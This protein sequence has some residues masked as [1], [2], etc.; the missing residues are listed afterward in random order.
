MNIKLLDTLCC[1]KCK[2]ALNLQEELYNESEIIKGNLVCEKCSETYYILQGIPS[3]YIS[4]DEIIA[5]SKKLEFD[6]F[7]ITSDR[8]SAL[9]KCN[10]PKNRLG[11]LSN[12]QI[13]LF[14]VF[15]GWLL[16]FLTCLWVAYETVT[17][18]LS[19]DAKPLSLVF[20][21]ILILIL[22]TSDYIIYRLDAKDRYENQLQRLRQLNDGRKLSEYDS[23]LEFKDNKATYSD[24]SKPSPKAKEIALTLKKYGL[25]GGKGLNAGCGGEIHQWVSRPF[26]D[27]GYDMLGLD[28]SEEYLVEYRSIFK[29]EGI[30]ANIMALPLKDDIF[31][32]IY[33]T[34]ILEHLHH[35]FLGLCEANR[36][37]RNGGRILLSTPYRS[38]LSTRGINPLIFIESL[39]SLFNDRILG[40]RNMLS[41]FQGME[42][43]HLE[44]SKGEIIRML[45][46]AGF[47][48]HSFDTYFAKSKI[49]TKI[50]QKL[51][52]LRFMGGSIM[53]IGVKLI[54]S[55]TETH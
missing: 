35:P 4:D 13:S 33:A 29:V 37:L 16:F 55:G 19:I 10:K 7:V 5:R 39:I 32:L 21:L 31:D 22:F 2:E 36:V 24:F 11:I 40:N 23:R 9:A 12:R 49:L 34:D 28:I 38:R 46:S 1:P 45:E 50:F 53:V 25:N 52:L 48:V 44:F 8:L 26:F 41:G 6:E 42:Y 18:S 15:S 14:L 43:Y 54:E 27:K 30:L 3:L 20:C 47:K 51:P 17:G